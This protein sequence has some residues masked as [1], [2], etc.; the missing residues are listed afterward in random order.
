MTAVHTVRMIRF[1]PLESAHSQFC[2]SYY[3]KLFEVEDVRSICANVPGR[4]LPLCGT[5]DVVQVLYPS[6]SCPPLFPAVSWQIGEKRASH[7][8]TFVHFK[9]VYLA[10]L[11]M[12][13]PSFYN[14]NSSPSLRKTCEN[15]DPSGKSLSKRRLQSTT[16]P[17]VPMRSLDWRLT[18]Q[19]SKTRKT[20]DQLHQSYPSI[21]LK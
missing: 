18:S 8:H 12:L 1:G 17:P 5:C 15:T 6:R 7:I 19:L 9:H 14:T 16:G 13:Y 20:V 3:Y 4:S 11:S 10:A 21:Q 2:F